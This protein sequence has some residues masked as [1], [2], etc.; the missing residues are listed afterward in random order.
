LERMK[1]HIFTVMGRYRGRIHGWDVVNEAILPD[2]KY[3]NSKWFE[4]IGE[5]HVLKAYEYARQAD[6]DAQLYYNDYNMWK[7]PQYEG[8][9]RLVQDLQSKGVQIDGVGIQGH[10]GLDYPTVTEIEG[11]IATLSTLGV[12]LM[13]TE[14]DVSVIPY[15]EDYDW[16]TDISTLSAELQ[17]KFDPYPD[18]TPESVQQDLTKRYD[19]LFAIFHKHRQKIGRVTFWAI[20][21]EQSWR[22]YM[23]LSTRTDYPMLFDR[24]L[25]PKPAFDAVVKRWQSRQSKLN[26]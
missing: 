22:N 19:E 26:R 24:Q 14:L 8:V 21:D 1:E 15:T 23:P 6:P 13:I 3:R 9:I 2:G 20:H 18:G 10:W 16:G 4:I 11:F 25:Q 5:D 12:K 7:K 17:K